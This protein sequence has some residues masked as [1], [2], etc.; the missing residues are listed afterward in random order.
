MQP[1]TKGD[2]AHAVYL[3]H[4]RVAGASDKSLL[5]DPL[6]ADYMARTKVNLPTKKYY[7]QRF[8]YVVV[9]AGT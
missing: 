5:E 1:R 6:C 3:N 7:G 9:Q 2:N 4:L 8:S